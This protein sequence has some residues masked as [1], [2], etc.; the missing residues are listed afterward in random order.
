MPLIACIAA[1][2]AQYFGELRLFYLELP[3]MAYYFRLCVL[4]KINGSL[5]ETVV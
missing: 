2:L 5:L 1:T 3:V 4:K